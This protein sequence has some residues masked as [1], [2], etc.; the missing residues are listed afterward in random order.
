MNSSIVSINPGNSLYIDGLVVNTFDSTKNLIHISAGQCRDSKN[1]VDISVSNGVNSVLVTTSFVGPGGVDIGPTVNPGLYAIYVLWDSTGRKPVSGLASMR[2]N[3]IIPAG[4]DSYRLVGFKGTD[5]SGFFDDNSGNV[6]TSN[7]RY[8]IYDISQT[9]LSTTTPATT[10]TQVSLSTI[11]P[12]YMNQTFLATFRLYFTG[13]TAT[14]TFNMGPTNVLNTV[15]LVAP[16]L[17]G[18]I[19]DQ[20]ETFCYNSNGLNYIWY[21]SSS[22]LDVVGIYLDRFYYSV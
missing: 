10:P 17:G 8:F 21:K 13:G 9:V 14:S 22:A 12:G 3:P 19:S 4:Y 18:S 1:N 2:T 11:L 16:S 20:V 7:L 6:G 15:N 5:N